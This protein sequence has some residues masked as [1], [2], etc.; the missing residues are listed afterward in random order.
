MRMNHTRTAGSGSG[1]V[2]SGNPRPTAAEVAQAALATL[3]A[4]E[5][6]LFRDPFADFQPSAR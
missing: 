2:G 6:L 5:D 1:A 3:L 4:S